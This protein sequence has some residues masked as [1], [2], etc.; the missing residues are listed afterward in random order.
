L[1]EKYPIAR[2]V[3]TSVHRLQMRMCF[4]KGQIWGRAVYYM[5]RGLYH[6]SKTYWNRPQ[7]C[8]R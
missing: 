1:R 2:D 4:K 7:T 6:L 8:Y 3:V 5:D